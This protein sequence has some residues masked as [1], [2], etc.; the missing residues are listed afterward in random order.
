M[1]A[2]SPPTIN[3]IMRRL[4]KVFFKETSLLNRQN[5][6]TVF[7]PFHRYTPFVYYL[8]SN[9]TS[10]LFVMQKKLS[11]VDLKSSPPIIIHRVLH[12]NRTHS[13]Y[14]FPILFIM[15]TIAFTLPKADKIREICLLWHRTNPLCQRWYRFWKYM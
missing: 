2:R 13:S 10:V 14:P 4:V 3:I 12:W 9:S 7:H 1:C 11:A 15:Q 8:K 5:S 6:W